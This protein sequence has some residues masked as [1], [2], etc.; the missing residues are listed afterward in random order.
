MGSEALFLAGRPLH[1][2]VDARARLPLPPAPHPTHPQHTG[3]DTKQTPQ[4][5]VSEWEGSQ[6]VGRWSFRQCN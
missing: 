5:S 4:I 3:A 6:S 2:H 1:W